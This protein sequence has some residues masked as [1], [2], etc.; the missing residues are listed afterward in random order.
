V[1]Q[2]GFVSQGSRVDCSG[3]SSWYLGRE[4]VGARRVCLFG[5]MVILWGRR[6]SHGSRADG[7]FEGCLR[8]IGAI[9]K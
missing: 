9:E 2:V 3:G 5:L 6:I 8:T 1:K 4:N 7:R